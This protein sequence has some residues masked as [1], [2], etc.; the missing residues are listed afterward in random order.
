M[1][2]YVSP[3]IHHQKTTSRRINILNPSQSQTVRSLD[4]LKPFFESLNQS[5]QLNPLQSLKP[6]ASEPHLTATHW[7]RAG[8]DL[9]T[10]RTNKT[11]RGRREDWIGI[12]WKSWGY[13][14]NWF[15]KPLEKG[16]EGENIYT[17]LYFISLC[18]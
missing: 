16:I 5:S 14:T 4:I 8:V 10:W 3:H 11:A 13:T 9:S 2:P 15:S 12:Q 18:V 1:F 17:I 7:Y 6:V